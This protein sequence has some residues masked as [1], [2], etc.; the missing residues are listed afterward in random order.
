MPLRECDIAARRQ[1][2]VGQ[3]LLQL[4][5]LRLLLPL[6]LRLRLLLLRLLGLVEAALLR[7]LLLEP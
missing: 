1:Q 6:R 5:G 4:L 7:L 2:R 3:Q